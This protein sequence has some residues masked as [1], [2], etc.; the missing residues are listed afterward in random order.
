MPS[1]GDVVWLDF[2]GVVETKRRLT[3]TGMIFGT[4]EY[5]APEQASGKHADLRAE[6]TERRRLV[7]E[8]S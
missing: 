8:K 2:P 6:L 3:R 5:M 7:G 4:P 1:A